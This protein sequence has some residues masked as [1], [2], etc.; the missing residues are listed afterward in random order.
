MSMEKKKKPLARALLHEWSELQTA[1]DYRCL[2]MEAQNRVDTALV[3]GT[4]SSILSRNIA[5]QDNKNN[6]YNIHHIHV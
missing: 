5:G 2:T 4:K 6:I 3:D 1:D